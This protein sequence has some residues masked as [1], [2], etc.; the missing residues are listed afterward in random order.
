MAG[1]FASMGGFVASEPAFASLPAWALSNWPGR[2]GPP[3]QSRGGH[4]PPPSPTPF[5]I[6]CLMWV[7][8]GSQHSVTPATLVLGHHFIGLGARLQGFRQL[9]Y[10]IIQFPLFIIIICVYRV[11]YQVKVFLLL[12]SSSQWQHHGGLLI[13]LLKMSFPP[14]RLKAHLNFHVVNY[15]PTFAKMS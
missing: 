6:L 8:A 13:F 3:A 2:P 12:G 11:I 5:L 14:H 15:I 4:P 7:F 9:W 1:A 10:P